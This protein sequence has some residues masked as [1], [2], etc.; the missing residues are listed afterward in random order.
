LELLEA[1]CVHLIGRVFSGRG[2]LGAI[3]GE[4]RPARR[5]VLGSRSP[6]REGASGAMPVGPSLRG[7]V[8]CVA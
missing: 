8:P 4:E 6:I 7:R 2:T 1:P 5:L 3:C